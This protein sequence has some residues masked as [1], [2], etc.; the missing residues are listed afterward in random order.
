[1]AARYAIELAKQKPLLGLG[2]ESFN[3]HLRA[4]LDIPSSAVAGVMNTAVAHDASEP[5][6]DDSHNTYLQLLAGTG[7][8]G[9]GL[10]LALAVSGLLAVARAFRRS[11]EPQHLAVLLGLVLFHFY[12]LFQGMA[13][14]PVLFFLYPALAGYATTL[15]PGPLPTA[16]RRTPWAW[17]LA[18]GAVVLVSAVGYAGD[19]GYASLKRRFSV[20]AYLPDE[21]AEFE[22]FYSPETGPSG[23]FRWMSRRGIVNVSR[24]TPF[25][26]SITCDH[27][28]AASDP[29]VLSLRFE[30]RDAGSIVFR[31]LKTV[32][33]RFDF[34]TPGSL[35]L[36]VSRT[37]RPGGGADRELG[38]S[39]SAIRW[40]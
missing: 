29:V 24:A 9:L 39:V 30:G 40:E 26:L 25:R 27:P 32:E 19:R 14:I 20:T 35:R 6:F 11:G 21:A 13:Y 12:G 18:L 28:D 7:A 2:Y 31:R 34:G 38:V 17:L 16:A 3:M 8:V 4:Q 5:L 22:G 36:E 1:V 37:F 33:R 10:W 23:E 15:D